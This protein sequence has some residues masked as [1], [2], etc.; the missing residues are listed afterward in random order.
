M[1]FNAFMGSINFALSILRAFPFGIVAARAHGS[2]SRIFK[3]HVTG[4][5]H[6]GD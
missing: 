1:F 6:E 2:F 4:L 5:S 3:V